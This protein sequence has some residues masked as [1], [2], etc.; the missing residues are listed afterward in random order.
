MS[1]NNHSGK[2][3]RGCGAAGAFL[4]LFV[5]LL[6]VLTVVFFFTDIFGSA[7]RSLYGVFYP[8]KYTEQVERYSGEFGVDPD[9][10]YAVI[11]TESGFREDVES[12]AGAIGLMQM[13][14]STF[15]WLQEKLEGEIVYSPD[16]LTDPDV[17]IRYGTYYLSYLI[18]RYGDER[19]AL[20]A[21]NAGGAAVDGWLE[22][23]SLSS[24]GRTL[25]TIPYSETQAY[26]DKVL[27]ARDKYRELY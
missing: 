15:D 6:A 11:R 25:D 17:S 7:K 16:M 14:P 9:L 19:T 26:V 23:G 10:V 5:L 3:N 4:T 21:Y 2:K 24:D 1:R 22:D 18:E 8:V 27:N 12:G 20:A 13:M